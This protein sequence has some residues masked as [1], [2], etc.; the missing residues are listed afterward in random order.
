MR[1]IPANATLGTEFFLTR[2]MVFTA[3]GV[4]AIL[5]KQEGNQIALKLQ[6]DAF[7]PGILIVFFLMTLTIKVK[8]ENVVV[9]F[10][11]LSHHFTRFCQNIFSNFLILAT[12]NNQAEK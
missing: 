1:D 8:E 3:V 10:V 12:T 4:A 9:S 11:V 6:S 7:Y 5:K 2:L